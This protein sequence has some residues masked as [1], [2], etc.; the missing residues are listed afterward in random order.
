MKG[1]EFVLGS[2]P[3]CLCRNEYM[4]LSHRKSAF[5]SQRN[6]IYDLYETYRKRKEH[7]GGYDAAD[8]YVPSEYLII[9]RLNYALAFMRLFLLQMHGYQVVSLIVC[10]YGRSGSG[11]SGSFA[12]K[13]TDTSMR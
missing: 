8:R 11:S 4:N 1:S 2:K 6:R 3:G 9:R 5:A 10:E 13:H 7:L 12:F